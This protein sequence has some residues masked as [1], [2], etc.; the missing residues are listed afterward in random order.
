[1]DRPAENTPKAIRE[2]ILDWHNAHKKQPAPRDWYRSWELY[3]DQLRK[4]PLMR[5]YCD[6]KHGPGQYCL[7]CDGLQEDMWRGR[8][9]FSLPDD[10]KREREWIKHRKLEDIRDKVSGGVK[11]KTHVQ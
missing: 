8:S 11:I 9:E 4:H 1:M 6:K 3:L 5:D 2:F 10:Y 7:V